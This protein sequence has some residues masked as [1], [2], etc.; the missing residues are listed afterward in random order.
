MWQGAGEG[1]L[2]VRLVLID[3]HT[4]FR[5]GLHA[6]LEREPDLEIVGEASDARSAYQLVEQVNPDVALVDIALPGVNGIAVTRELR[7]TSTCKVLVL[8]MHASEDFVSQAFAAGASGYAVKDQKAHEMVDAIRAVGSGRSYLCPRISRI[9]LEDSQRL[10]RGEPLQKDGPCMMLSPR[11]REVFDLLVRGFSNPRVAGELCI[12][13]KTVETHRA[14]I[15][16]K[17]RLHSMVELVRFAAR[18]ELISD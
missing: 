7:R 6:I 14:H 2:K 1:K 12:S 13:V 3:D 8:S 4:L 11:E 17:L 16:K 5:E 9:V 18:H 10:R 15:L